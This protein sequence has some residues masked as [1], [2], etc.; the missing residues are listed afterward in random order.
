VDRLKFAKYTHHLRSDLAACCAA[1]EPRYV[2]A[3]KYACPRVWRD[4]G[5]TRARCLQRGT[6]AMLPWSS[7]AACFLPH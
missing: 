5:R 3:G 6:G 2:G 1:S 4:Y 7:Q